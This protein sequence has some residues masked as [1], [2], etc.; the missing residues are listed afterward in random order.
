MY[1]NYG[2][3]DDFMET[4]AQFQ[5][6]FPLYTVL[7]RDDQEVGSSRSIVT[8]YQIADNVGGTITQNGQRAPFFGGY[9]DDVTYLPLETVVQCTE[10]AKMCRNGCKSSEYE[11]TGYCYNCWVSAAERLCRICRVVEIP[12][13]AFYDTCEGCMEAFAEGTVPASAEY[14]EIDDC[15]GAYDADMELAEE[16]GW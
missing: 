10:E 8:A 5:E 4:V 7:N 9:K 16:L 6:P 2:Q 14:R 3:V 1:Q 11:S 13:D 15:P 12:S